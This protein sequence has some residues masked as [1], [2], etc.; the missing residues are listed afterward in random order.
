M[1]WNV[2]CVILVG[3]KSRR[4]GQDK[5]FIHVGE[6]RLFDYVYGT[7]KDRFPETLIITNQPPQFSKYHAHIIADEIPGTGSLGRLYTGLITA[8]NYYVFC[9]AC[10]MPFF[11][12]ELIIHLTE[13]RFNYDVVIPSTGNGL[14]LLHTLYSKRCI[15][16]TKKILG[17][18]EFK[19]TKF[20]H[21]MHVRFCDEEEIQKRDPLLHR[22]STL[23]PQKTC[24]RYRLC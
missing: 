4:L 19:I 10:D 12:P 3:G 11:Q 13:K 17:E 2:S 15:V 9:V 5:A 1:D 6:S 16:P 14:E 21:E 22:L 20:F 8:S 7:C 18:G 24:L 23:M